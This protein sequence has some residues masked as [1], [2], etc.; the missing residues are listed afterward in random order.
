MSDIPASISMSNRDN[1]F[2]FATSSLASQL[3]DS[4][5][6]YV[7]LFITSLTVPCRA[8]NADCLLSSSSLW[9]PMWWP[10]L[11]WS[12]IGTMPTLW[13]LYSC[14][15]C[16][17]HCEFCIINGTSPPPQCTLATRDLKHE[18]NKVLVII[19]MWVAH[20]WTHAIFH[21]KYSYFITND[22]RVTYDCTRSIFHIK[23][24]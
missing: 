3:V 18:T 5:A 14:W 2:L 6:L 21:I 24:S 16:S 19:C 13:I 10:D 15:I 22:M 20:D 12:V 4:M 8:A 11:T 17:W 7:T 23:Y 9:V 1:S